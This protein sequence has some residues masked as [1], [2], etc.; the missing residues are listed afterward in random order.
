MNTRYFE[1]INYLK[2]SLIEIGLSIKSYLDSDKAC[3]YAR[4]EDELSMSA[5][6]SFNPSVILLCHSRRLIGAES[7]AERRAK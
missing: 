5:Q 1:C 7:N 3:L 2:Q 6:Y 4:K